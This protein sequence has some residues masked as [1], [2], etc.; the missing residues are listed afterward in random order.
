MVYR[1]ATLL[2]SPIV[3]YAFLGYGLSITFIVLVAVLSSYIFSL[4][5][6]NF[7]PE[8]SGYIWFASFIGTLIAAGVLGQL[9]DAI[10]SQIAVA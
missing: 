9:S 2:F 3:W 10:V 1:P 7:G 8:Q 6:Y 4:P 5:P